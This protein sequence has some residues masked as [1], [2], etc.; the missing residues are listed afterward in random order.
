[1]DKLQFISKNLLIA[2]E[3]GSGKTNF[4][5]YLINQITEEHEKTIIYINDLKGLDYLKMIN[6]LN[7]FIYNEAE[8]FELI[9]H[10][11]EKLQDDPSYD[12]RDIYNL[13]RI[14]RCIRILVRFNKKQI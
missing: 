3:I 4:L 8:I 14:S 13:R 9:D 12:F 2:G 6:N 11:L 7:V 5:K 10:R 1:M